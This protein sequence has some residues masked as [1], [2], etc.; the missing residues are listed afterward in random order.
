MSYENFIEK[1]LPNKYKNIKGTKKLGI[2]IEENNNN[3]SDFEKSKEFSIITTEPGQRKSFNNR[4][5][6]FKNIS[7]KNKNEIE[8]DIKYQTQKLFFN[9]KY[10]L[11]MMNI[12][13]NS[14]SNIKNKRKNNFNLVNKNKAEDI[15][16]LNSGKKPSELIKLISTNNSDSVKNENY[17]KNINLN[18]NINNNIQ[19]EVDKGKE[20]EDD[21]SELNKSLNSLIKIA[22]KNC[23]YFNDSIKSDSFNNKKTDIKKFKEKNKIDKIIKDKITENQ[24]KVKE[25]NKKIFINSNS[26]TKVQEKSNEFK[27]N[28]NKIIGNIIEN[29]IP[30]EK[31]I[32]TKNYIIPKDL[33]PK[34]NNKNNKE[35]IYNKKKSI[36]KNPIIKKKRN[37]SFKLKEKEENIKIYQRIKK[38]TNNTI[39]KGRMLEDFNQKKGDEHNSINLKKIE[40]NE[41][42]DKHTIFEYNKSTYVNSFNQN[43]FNS[44]TFNDINSKGTINN[45]MAKN[46]KYFEVNI[47]LD[48]CYPNKYSFENNIEDSTNK[49]YKRPNIFANIIKKVKSLDKLQNKKDLNLSNQNSS[50][51]RRNFQLSNEFNKAKTNINIINNNKNI[52]PLSAYMKKNLNKPIYS[53]SINTN[54]NQNLYIHKKSRNIGTYEERNTINTFNIN[55][56]NFKKYEDIYNNSYQKNIFNNKLNFAT[57]LGDL[58]I[59]EEKLC[60]VIL[61]LKKNKRADNQSLDFIIYFFNFSMYKQIEKVFE[62][63]IDEEIV[64]LS[65][66]YILL[67]ILL[68]YNFS[69]NGEIIDVPPFLEILQICHRNLINI[70]EQVLNLIENQNDTRNIWVEKLRQIVNYS[71]KSS[72]SIFSS[73]NYITSLIGK[74]N[75]NTNC[76]IKKLKNIL[77]KNQNQNKNI[78]INFVKNLSQKTYEE[79]N[80]FFKEYIY[81][82]DNPEGSILP[83]VYKPNYPNK[84]IQNYP[85][86][87]TPNK[88]RYSLILDLNE[89]LINLKYSH[90]SKG[91][92][93]V[94]PYL[95]QFLDEVSVN[96]ELILFTGSNQ[97]FVFPI[98]EVLEKKKKYFD[99][100]F[101]RQ[102]LVR[103]GDCYLKDLSK[104]GRPLDSTI[105]ID[106]NPQN[107]KLHKENGICIKSFWGDNGRDTALFDLIKIL[108]N[109]AKEKRDVRDEISKY[110]DEIISKISAC[111]S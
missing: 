1:K 72:E 88:K 29:K 37:L 38:S 48:N 111:I 110:K 95:Y 100:V 59:L 13:N 34:V 54:A 27:S 17:T 18:I 109:F 25:E 107:F 6:S 53:N 64:R 8:S 85:Y 65:L 40:N 50:R 22:E 99:F 4:S 36:P 43:T 74:I 98:I 2:I 32:K 60:D 62:N 84:Q 78:I 93:R 28:E 58:L 41:N 81:I 103:C 86:I 83:Q 104:I 102:Y 46:K 45:K 105:I 61:A 55:D 23:L 89:T 3:N 20:K 44:N 66:N 10:F 26:V 94:R 7:F 68:C 73:E 76:L 69:K 91:L 51:Q 108:N 21:S 35:K 33:I 67:S 31:I 30:Q 16:I 39:L 15:I 97:N 70:Y 5:I 56:F 42:N 92:I 9:K 106:N 47:S 52:K 71:K 14:D 12:E 57:K 101:Y 82:I 24:L 11:E 90:N 63:D 79:I 49:I 77:F 19:Y 87:K 75:F 80:Y 96:Y